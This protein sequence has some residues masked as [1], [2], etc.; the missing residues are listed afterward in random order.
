MTA[1]YTFDVFSSLDGYGAAGG[2]WT[3]YWGKQGPELL[4]HRLALYDT[5]QRMVLGAGTYRLFARMLASST[6]DSDVRDPWVT[7][8]RSLPATVVS[9]T[10]EGP[11][12]WPDA[13]VVSGDAVDVVARLKEESDVP[14]RSHGSLSMNRALMAAGLVDRLQVTLFPVIT[15]RTGLDPV[16]RGAADFDLELV[17]HRTLDGDIQELVYRP[18]LH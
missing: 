3:G 9:T 15:G 7:R 6:E 2:D 1:T 10:L 5:D 18:A 13:T 12:D 4:D 16:F 8:M 11:L 17:E 14:L